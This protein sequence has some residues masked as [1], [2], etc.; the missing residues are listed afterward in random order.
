MAF[1]ERQTSEEEG[2]EG[3]AEERDSDDSSDSDAGD[4][5]PSSRVKKGKRPRSSS[6]AR[7]VRR[8]VCN[9]VWALDSLPLNESTTVLS[10]L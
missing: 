5:E 8:A 3:D 1:F 4:F 7:K 2:E 10:K 6:L 9:D